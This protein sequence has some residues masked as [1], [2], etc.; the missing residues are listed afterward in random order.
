MTVNSFIAKDI[1]ELEELAQACGRAGLKLQLQP[2]E[3]QAKSPCN[4]AKVQ[5]AEE[6]KARGRYTITLYSDETPILDYDNLANAITVRW[7]GWNATTA[8][9]IRAFMGG[10]IPKSTLASL[11]VGN[12]Y[13]ASALLEGRVLGA[14]AGLVMGY[15]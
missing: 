1:D 14:I 15:C 3:G 5:I 10:Y 12:R 9:H 6:D 13:S 8:Q 2:L 7:V 4:K 11:K